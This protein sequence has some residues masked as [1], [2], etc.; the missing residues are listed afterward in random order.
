MGCVFV[1][2]Q[3]ESAGRVIEQCGLKGT[4]I[5]GAYISE[6]HA[7]FVISDGGCAEDVAR[8]VELVARKV[9]EKTGISLREEIKRLP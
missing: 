8:L 5:G 1:N 3:G 7:N 2:P 6:R 4:R 9:K